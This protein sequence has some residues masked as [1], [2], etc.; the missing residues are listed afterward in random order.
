MTVNTPRLQS[1]CA[2]AAWW[3]GPWGA[4]GIN[5]S[6]R[7]DE[8]RGRGGSRGPVGIR[9][10]LGR[11]ILDEWLIKWSFPHS[12][13]GNH[14]ERLG[15]TARASFYMS[16]TLSRSRPR[17]HLPARQWPASGRS[18]SLPPSLSRS[19][20][21]R[22]FSAGSASSYPS[23]SIRA[24]LPVTFFSGPEVSKVSRNSSSTWLSSRFVLSPA[25]GFCASWWLIIDVIPPMP[26]GPL[27]GRLDCGAGRRSAVE[28]IAARR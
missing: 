13:R 28:S 3:C 7:P 25:S 21:T 2:T 9:W 26:A 15:C 24:R 20:Y 1:R 6:F 27:R 11:Q 4:G 10:K 8:V 22:R 12:S 19:W 16:Y 14:A 17:W 5:G 23:L 18:L